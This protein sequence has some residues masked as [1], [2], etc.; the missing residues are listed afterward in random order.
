MQHVTA[1]NWTEIAEMAPDFVVDILQCNSDQKQVMGKL[2]KK[3]GGKSIQLKNIICH[4]Y[5]TSIE[6][7]STDLV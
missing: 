2:R 3:K 5:N 4:G 6:I 1:K 7:T